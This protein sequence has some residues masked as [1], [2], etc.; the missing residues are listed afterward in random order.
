M[1]KVIVTGANGFIGVHICRE[2]VA[3]GIEVVAVVRNA[4]EDTHSLSDLEALRIVYC[5]KAEYSEL[6]RRVESCDCDTIYHLA[7]EGVSD[8]NQGEHNIQLENIKTT[9]SLFDVLPQ[10]GVSTFIGAGSLWEKECIIDI[11]NNT[12]TTNSNNMYK[13][14]KVAAHF[15]SK[16]RAGIQGTNFIWPIITNTFGV[17][18]ASQRLIVTLIKKLA[19]GERPA[20][21]S[22]EQFYDFVYITDL[23]RAFYLIGEKGKSG[24]EYVIGSGKPDRL[25]N[26]ICKLRDIVAPEVEL[27]FGEHRYAGINVPMEVFD[28]RNLLDDTGF[29]PSVS[30]EDGVR[31]TRD[32]ILSQPKTSKA[33]LNAARLL[34]TGLPPQS[35]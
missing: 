14:A 26:F 24:R 23:A 32:W 4:E 25:K 10:M 13:I 22:G 35:N 20:L 27:G 16:V 5:D 12:S 11:S 18:E 6:P 1:K 2:L 19:K 7:W 34:P 31:M 8:R 30:F 9:V 29:V 33:T 17:G 15:M 28:N 3:N 21:T